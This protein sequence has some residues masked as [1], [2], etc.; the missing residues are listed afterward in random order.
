[1]GDYEIKGFWLSADDIS[2]EFEDYLES[3]EK[4][5]DNNYDQH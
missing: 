4:K 1:M 2:D 3:F 5:G